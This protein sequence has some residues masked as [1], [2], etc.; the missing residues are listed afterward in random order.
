MKRLILVTITVFFLLPIVSADTEQ[1]HDSWH[2]YKTNIST[3]GR[4]FHVEL[5]QNNERI[6]VENSETSASV[7]Y[8]DCSRLNE[9]QICYD[10][11]S[12]NRSV[13]IDRWGQSRPGIQISILKDTG[14]RE[15]V[16]PEYEYEETVR[17]DEEAG[18]IIRYRNVNN[19]VIP[20][21]NQDLENEEIGMKEEIE[22]S[23]DKGENQT[24]IV[25][26]T[27]E[28]TGSYNIS[29]T[30]QYGIEGRLDTVESS[31]PLTVLDPYETTSTVSNTTATITF[32]NNL[33]EENISVTLNKVEPEEVHA[34]LEETKIAEEETITIPINSSQPG[35]YSIRLMLNVEAGENT[36]EEIITGEVTIPE[37]ETKNTTNQTETNQTDSDET[38][39][40]SEEND[41][42]PNQTQP[43]TPT[44][45][46]QNNS[47]GTENNGFFS[48]VI[49]WWIGLFE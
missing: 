42:E 48:S 5:S 24:K 11:K 39:E 21:V 26:F 32:T 38:E 45:I 47:T 31:L 25:R 2:E 43:E 19:M 9:Y 46:T 27:P 20:I 13:R 23:I 15:R 40:S 1:I 49:E 44:N 35:T 22:T 17:V 16:N 18:I 3:D 36:L 34:T 10:N 37:P 8:R 28:E 14:A 4:T 41:T 29:S 12:M 30:L 33:D 6:R 7:N